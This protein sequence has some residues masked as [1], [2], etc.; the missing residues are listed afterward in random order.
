MSRLHKKQKT[1]ALD[2]GDVALSYNLEKFFQDLGTLFSASSQ[3][4][5]FFWRRDDYTNPH[6][7]RA[8]ADRGLSEYEIYQAFVKHFHAAPSFE[9]FIQTFNTSCEL[10]L[11]DG[12]LE[13]RNALASARLDLIVLS[14]LTK[15]HRDY[16]V[17]TM[18]HIFDPHIPPEKRFFSCDLGV[19]KSSNPEH[20]RE[21]AHKIHRDIESLILIDDRQTNIDGIVAAGGIGILHAG[22]FQKTKAELKKYHVL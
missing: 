19:S 13:F 18:T 17:T 1:I 9:T 7:L 4:I 16:I 5:K 21:I 2:L 12:F 10:R 22:D 8:H 14:N 6:S 15:P 20:F 11:I 3:D